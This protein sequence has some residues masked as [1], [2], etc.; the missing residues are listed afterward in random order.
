MRGLKWYGFDKFDHAKRELESRGFDVVSPADLD[1]E[2]GFNPFDLP[3]DHDWNTL[4]VGFIL[5]HAVLRDIKAL[6]D[7]HAIALLPG[8]E[9]SQ[10]ATAE[11]AVAK[12]LGLEVL[13]PTGQPYEASIL[14]EAYRITRGD[15]NDDYGHPL[16]EHQNIASG[17]SVILGTTVTAEQ[18]ALSMIW[19]KIA[20]SLHRFKRDSAT[21]MAGY[22]DCLWRIIEE[23]ERRKVEAGTAAF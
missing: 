1:R 22:A 10:R 6:S 20:R 7:C 3:E 12:W 14:T 15:R 18:V 9:Q 2:T 13:D 4:P 17:W 8:W 19:L 23:R 5:K 21:D 11:L 16:D